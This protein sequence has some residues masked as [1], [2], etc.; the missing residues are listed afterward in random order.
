MSVAVH[1]L[2][3]NKSLR[4]IL[5]LKGCPEWHDIFI[6]FYS[7]LEQNRGGKQ[8]LFGYSSLENAFEPEI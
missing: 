4:R 8:T 2:T 1:R 7:I 5:H 3:R 6:L